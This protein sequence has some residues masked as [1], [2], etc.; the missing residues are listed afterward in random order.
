MGQVESDFTEL[1]EGQYFVTS[2]DAAIRAAEHFYVECANFDATMATVVS[3]D[4]PVSFELDAALVNAEYPRIVSFYI[5]HGCYG[6][7][8]RDQRESFVEIL[9]SFGLPETLE[10]T[11]Q[12]TSRGYV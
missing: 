1:S 2:Y 5:E 6:E 7:A 4:A 9:Y 11:A 10:M 12:F 8:C 3:E